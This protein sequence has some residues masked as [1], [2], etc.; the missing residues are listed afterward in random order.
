MQTSA[1][2]VARNPALKLLQSYVWNVTY[3][4]VEQNVTFYVIHVR[5]CTRRMPHLES[6]YNNPSSGL[7]VLPT[8]CW[9]SSKLRLSRALCWCPRDTRQMPW[10][11][12]CKFQYSG[13]RSKKGNAHKNMLRNFYNEDLHIH[14]FPCS[15]TETGWWKGTFVSRVRYTDASYENH[16]YPNAGICL[17]LTTLFPFK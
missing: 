11:H 12:T 6:S 7:A 4:L 13:W 1:V 8:R 17:P 5:Q 2:A 15:S 3:L 14:W 16:L 9:S 10:P